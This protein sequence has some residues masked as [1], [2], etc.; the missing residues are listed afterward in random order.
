MIR[1]RVALS[2]V[3]AMGNFTV[4]RGL[5]RVRFATRTAP[6][7][8]P[9]A[10]GSYSIYMDPRHLFSDERFSG[11]CVF[12]GGIPETTDHCPSKVLL[13]EPFPANLAAVDSC[14][15]CNH[16]FS[17][18][19]EYLACFIECVIT[20]F[21]TV[22]DLSRPNIKRILTDKPALTK[23]ILGSKQLGE[24]GNA[25]WQPETSRISRVIKKLARGHLAFELSLPKLDEPERLNF[26]SLVT[27]SEAKRKQFEIP[28]E[29]AVALWPEVG[30]RAFFRATR[31]ASHPVDE[32]ITSQPGR[33]R[34]LVSQSDGDFVQIVLSEYL[35]C[36]VGWR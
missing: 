3:S 13:D 16:S 10:T 19:E 26:E 25:T 32:W 18:D 12:C 28:S 29:G 23:M 35:A 36:R 1:E 2:N 20:G 30:S 7:W 9:R 33:Y 17:I 8:N 4:R 24:G 5:R 11:F 21:T 34:Y 14:R 27:M 22:A 31:A 6:W 15:D